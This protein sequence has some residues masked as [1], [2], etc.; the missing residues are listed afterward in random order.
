M[1]TLPSVKL[2]QPCPLSRWVNMYHATSAFSIPTLPRTREDN[3]VSLQL[4]L[5]HDELFEIYYWW[6]TKGK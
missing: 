2:P 4:H 6:C 3:H 5:I 1:Y